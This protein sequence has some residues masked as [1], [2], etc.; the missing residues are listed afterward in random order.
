MDLS[1]DDELSGEVDEDEVVA[2]KMGHAPR[3]E[4]QQPPRPSP[5]SDALPIL[6]DIT[7]ICSLRNDLDDMPTC[8]RHCDTKASST[9]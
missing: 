8:R 2:M 7:G 6:D 5:A 1:N 3:T 9:S 4:Q